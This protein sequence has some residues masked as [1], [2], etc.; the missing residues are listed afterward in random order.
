MGQITLVTGQA[1][2]GKTTWLIEKVRERAPLLLSS[3]HQRVLAI[4]RMHGARRRVQDKLNESC[5]GILCSVA[6]VDGF[7]LSILNRWRTALGWSK[8]IRSVNG[9]SD[10][11]ETVFGL[12][13]DFKRVLLGATRLLQ[14][15]LVKRILSEAYPLIAIDEF[16]DC[17]GPLLEFVKS[18]SSCSSMLLA[19]DDFQ[20]L[21]ASTPGCPAVEWVQCLREN[22]SADITELTECH[23]TNVTS[24]L[25]AAR[26]LRDNIKSSTPTI[27]VICC[28]RHL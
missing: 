11:M 4:T 1:G 20:L 17:H 16:Q 22:G 10:F 3:E 8:P 21:D 23:R 9:E 5:K 24:I 27:P 26:C 13:A 25:E 2:T 6:T 19:A 12:D 15:R 18:L 28:P 14:A 7:A